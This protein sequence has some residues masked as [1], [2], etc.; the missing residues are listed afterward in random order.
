MSIHWLLWIRIDK[1]GLWLI[2]GCITSSIKR[3]L[4]RVVIIKSLWR[5]R[6]STGRLTV[7]IPTAKRWRGHGRRWCVSLTVH[8]VYARLILEGSL[9]FGCYLS[10]RSRSSIRHWT[11]WCNFGPIPIRI[12]PNCQDSVSKRLWCNKQS[13]K[14]EY[15]PPL[16]S[17]K[18]K[19]R[20]TSLFILSCDPSTLIRYLIWWV[21]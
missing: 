13:K 9:P 14:I 2:C 18:E 7:G 20:R 11:G 16:L 8:C 15:S 1:A 6:S 3:R 4:W 17:K 5:I 10:T 21:W 12:V 19:V